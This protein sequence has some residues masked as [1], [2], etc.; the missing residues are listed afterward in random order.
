MIL[1][2]RLE[3][4][5]VITM[6]PGYPAA[7]TLGFWNGRIAGLDDMVSDL[8]AQQILD[9]RGATV[10]PGFIDAH[11]HLCWAGTASAAV[12]I[13]PCN[14][15][16]RVLETIRAAALRVPPGA[17]VDV[18]G[19]DQRSLGRHLTCR[20]LDTVSAGRKILLQH[21]SGHAC[22]VNSEVL[23]LLPAEA[24]SGADSGVDVDELGNLTGLFVE[25]ALL[26]VRRLRLP[27][28]IEEIVDALE[29]SAHQCVSE[30]I[31][32]CA[33]A[34][35][36]GGLIGHSPA[37]LA[38]Y[39]VA[40]EAARLPLRVQL[41]VSSDV[42]HSLAAHRDDHIA[43]G[44][45]LGLRT[46]FGD[47]WL[48]IGALKVYLD[49]GMMAR[50]AALTRPYYASDNLGQLQDDP[51]LLTEVVV[52][53]HKAGW[54]LAIHAIGDRAVDLALDALE[55]AHHA[56]PR[57]GT[58][59]RIEHCGLVRPDQ[60][61]R[62]ARAGAMAVVQPIFLWEYGDDYAEILGPE[63]APWMYR[64]RS[65]TDRDIVLVGSS[66]RPVAS[67]AP[68]RGIQFMV[69]RTSSSGRMIGPAESLSVEEA[70]RAYTVNAAFACHREQALGS[71]SPSKHAD[72]AVLA[73]DPRGVDPSRIAQIEVVATMVEGEF[74]HGA[75]ALV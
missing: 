71:I 27:Y 59:H 9:L 65:F 46:G 14:R 56:H 3:N 47:D 21:R 55:R 60:L 38:A 7:H 62:F 43:R 58:R 6:D 69:E 10:V 51:G 33:E 18:A 34:G 1:D 29:R 50:T 16:D 52:D 19:Y 20:D 25:R 75:A 40:R 31:T 44:L 61:D 2:L 30:G 12:D 64:G 74:M 66:D 22:L 67:G 63:R 36:G 49:G 35:I 8:P 68:L 39:Q 41:M 73:D 70:L 54:Q 28:S 57:A 26:L 32:M 37:E 17:W 13:S 24:R 72:V 53:G 15:R 42:L 5:N 4:G 11:T 23:G 45:D 48:S